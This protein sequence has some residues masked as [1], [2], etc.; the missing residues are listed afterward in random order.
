M[1]VEEASM[2]TIAIF[3]LPSD[4]GGV[5]YCAV[6][7]DRRGIGKTAGQALDAVTADFSSAE[8]DP[9]VVVRRGAADGLFTAK[10]QDRLQE[11]MQRWRS[12]R[13]AGKTL[14]ADQQ[15]ELDALIDAELRAATERARSVARGLR[16]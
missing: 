7:G 14:P 6:A 13:D 16:P 11:L 15:A 5:S 9:L 8:T 4:E 3:P 1:D 10:Q 2:T 12:A